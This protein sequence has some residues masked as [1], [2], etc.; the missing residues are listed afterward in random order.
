MFQV[1]KDKFEIKDGKIKSIKLNKNIRL[2]VK[3]SDD[4]TYIE[5]LKRL[6]FFIT[7][8]ISWSQVEIK[9]ND[10]GKWYAYIPVAVEFPRWKY[11]PDKVMGVDLGIANLMTSA[12]IENMKDLPTNVVMIP[13]GNTFQKL[14]RIQARVRGLRSKKDKGNSNTQKVLERLK[15]KKTQVQRS[16][17]RQSATKLVKLA[18]ENGVEG[19]AIENLRSMK[20]YSGKGSGKRNRLLTNWA[21]GESASFLQWKANEYGLRLLMIDPANT[22]RKCPV[23]GYISNRNRLTQSNFTCVKCGYHNHADIVGAINIAREGLHDRNPKYWGVSQSTSPVGETGTDSNVG[24]RVDSTSNSVGESL[25]PLTVKAE[26]IDG[27]LPSNVTTETSLNPTNGCY[28]ADNIG[29]SR[30]NLSGEIRSET[31]SSQKIFPD[32]GRQNIYK[33]GESSTYV[34]TPCPEGS[35]TD[36]GIEEKRE[37]PENLMSKT[38]GSRK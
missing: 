22:S 11:S 17:I 2:K 32:G 13:G 18:K 33:E 12:V 9:Q 25:N 30:R 14:E 20:V 27:G 1:G 38:G 5:R 35:R 4:P 7:K 23:C 34:T 26:Q 29:S 21:K 3:D 10:D 19:L 15:G 6:V 16:I 24:R 31:C 28:K 8:C 36:S 37:R